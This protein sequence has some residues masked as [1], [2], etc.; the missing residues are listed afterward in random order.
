MK[1]ITLLFDDKLMRPACVLLQA[2]AG[3][4]EYNGFLRRNFDASVWLVA[5]TPDMKRVVATQEEWLRIVAMTKP[6]TNSRYEAYKRSGSTENY[7]LWLR[8]RLSEWA[9]QSGRA[10]EMKAEHKDGWQFPVLVTPAHNR[11]F[12]LWLHNYSSSTKGVTTQTAG[13]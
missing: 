12:D 2:A 11:D 13:W 6:M 10:D 1:Q 9:K 8:A 5:L 4:G 7:A 3:Y